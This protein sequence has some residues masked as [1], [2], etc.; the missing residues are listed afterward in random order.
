MAPR[1]RRA[2]LRFIWKRKVFILLLMIL[3]GIWW[4]GQVVLK[5]INAHTQRLAEL[6]KRLDEVDF[7]KDP[8]LWTQLQRQLDFSRLE[9]M[10]W[11][12]GALMLCG[13]AAVLII[14]L[15]QISAREHP[16]TPSEDWLPKMRAKREAHIQRNQER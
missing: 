5:A 1:R 11:G 15:I 4:S 13:F 16:Q 3:G 2:I 14:S 12:L 10:L 7:S 6:Q 8:A 9:P